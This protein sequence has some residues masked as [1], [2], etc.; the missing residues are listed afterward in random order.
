VSPTRTP[1]SK[2]GGDGLFVDG[3]VGVNVLIGRAYG[4]GPKGLKVQRADVVDLILA[5][6]KRLDAAQL[7]ELRA[8]SLR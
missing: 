2:V 5:L 3:D 8:R 4:S 1:V 7:L 6:E